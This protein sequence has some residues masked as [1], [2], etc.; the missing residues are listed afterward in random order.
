MHKGQGIDIF[1]R[2]NHICPLEQDYEQMVT[3]KCGGLFMLIVDLLR[4]SS[5]VHFSDHEIQLI[6]Q[7]CN[8]LALLFQIRDDYLNLV[9]REYAENKSFCEDL[10]EGKYSFVV[11]HAIRKYPE[12]DRI[13]NIL[14]KRTRDIECKRE[15]LQIFYEFGSLHYAR[16]RCSLLASRC[17]DLINALNGNVFLKMILNQLMLTL[18]STV[19]ESLYDL[20]PLST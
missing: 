10:T 20:F 18:N 13:K 19:E 5:P 11:I 6:N 14:K 8:G 15:A 2:D 16:E 1:W 7:I 17:N 9:S 3:R 12:D 4:L